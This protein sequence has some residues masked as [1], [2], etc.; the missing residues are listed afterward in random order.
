MGTSSAPTEFSLIQIERMIA[1]RRQQL[2][3]LLKRRSDM[4]RKLKVLDER[5]R[6]VGG[7]GRIAATRA[8]NQMSLVE[9]IER[10]LS[11]AGT[12]LRVGDILEKVE[13]LGYHSTSPNFRAIVNQ[14][15]IKERRF[16]STQRGIYRLRL[17][18]IPA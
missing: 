10:V 6:E 5:I 7:A 15:L 2:A 18:T 13:R 9:A 8:Q 12:P 17:G 11:D 16:V 14:T 4:E 1:N 3:S